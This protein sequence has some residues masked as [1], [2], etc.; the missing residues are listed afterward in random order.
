MALS[1]DGTVYVSLISAGKIAALP[2][3]NRDGV[4]D[5]V[6]IW[7]EGLNGP[8]GLVF[9][10]G[11]LYVA[12]ATRVVRFKLGPNGQRQSDPEVVVPDLP[13]ASGHR[14]RTIGFDADGKLYVAVGS[15]CNVYDEPDQRRAAISLYNGDGSGG[16]VFMRGLRNAVGF[17]WR[18]GTSELWATNNG[19]DNLGDDVP[20]EGI[21]R[22]RESANAGWPN[23][24]VG[25]SGRELLPDPQFGKRDVC[26][27]AEPPATTFQAHSAPLGL[28]FYDGRAFPEALRGDL[29]VALHGSWNRSVPVGYRVI[30][31]PFA[32]GQAGQA[33]DF[34]TGWMADQGDRG[35]VWGRPV[36]LLVGPDG[37]LLISDDDGGAIF[38]IAPGAA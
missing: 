17:V 20:P 24:Y 1:D 25:P 4:A 15:S 31:I 14:T 36:D 32:G 27:A 6:S 7:A 37:A 3:R 11:Y 29:F 23:C 2:D 21:W 30:R 34:A 19:R 13:G 9:H 5:E 35:S 22:V 28:R 33:Q 10:A 8:H 18:P 38:R 26:R 16:R 12:E